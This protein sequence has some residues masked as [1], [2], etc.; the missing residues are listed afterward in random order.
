MTT[1]TD[2]TPAATDD[3]RQRSV[4]MSRLALV[5]L[6]KMVDTR[7]GFWLFAAMGIGVL[8]IMVAMLIW[9]DDGAMGFGN[10]FGLM[11][12]PTAFL[13]PVLAIL[14]VTSEWSQRTGLVTFALEPRRSRVV[15]AKL[16]VSLV[17][18]VAAVAFATAGATVGTLL[19]GVFR[20][21]GAQWD[22]TW[23]GF[24]NS[25]LLQFLALLQ[26]FAFG[27]LIMNSAAAIVLYFVLPTI[28][29]IV[30]QVVPWIQAN[31]QQWA[32]FSFTQMPFQSGEAATGQ[33]WAHLAVAGSVWL[34][35]PLVLGIWRL[36]RSEVK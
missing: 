30:S 3:I 32:D 35:L 31:L 25:A 22:M 14:L 28:W 11:N 12:I 18:A 24:G 26:G 7:A 16:A 13:L 6:R 17:A 4:P 2:T 5:E 21:S 15:V 29:S 9:A 19:A 1:V 20:D 27:M 36:L 8:I 23:V 34:V 33:E 10:M